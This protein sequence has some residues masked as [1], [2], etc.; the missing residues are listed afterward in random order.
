MTEQNI[1]DLLK[2]IEQPETIAEPTGNDDRSTQSL[3]EF[4]ADIEEAEAVD[5]AVV[6]VIDQ[7]LSDESLNDSDR[8][9]T[10]IISAVE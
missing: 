10:E 3:D 6:D 4:C 9:V 5:E 2:S 7:L 8:I 1:G